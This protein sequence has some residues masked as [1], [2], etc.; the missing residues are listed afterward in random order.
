MIFAMKEGK[1]P[2]RQVAAELSRTLF[3][4]TLFP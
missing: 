1:M 3:R 2:R 4:R